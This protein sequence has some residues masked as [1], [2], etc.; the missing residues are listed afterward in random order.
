MTSKYDDF[1]R[2]NLNDVD[3]LLGEAYESGASEDLDVSAIRSL[4]RRGSWY[5]L[6]DVKPGT[7]V[8][9]ETAHMTSLANV[10]AINHVLDKYAGA[11]FRF[12]LSTTLKLRATRLGGERHPASVPPEPDNE[13]FQAA[14]T[15]F[16]VASRALPCAPE[17]RRRQVAD[18][19]TKLTYESWE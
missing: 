17:M 16:E 18:I 19:L 8:R 7:C 15:L 10:L 13:A 6:A 11:R 5:G 2:Q 4:G 9:A 1:W 12:V 3:G 14:A